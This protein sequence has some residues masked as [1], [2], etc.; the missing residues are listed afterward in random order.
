MSFTEPALQG[1]DLTVLHLIPSL[2][3]GGT[4]RQL[5][6]FIN[7]SSRPDRHFVALFSSLGP[8]ATSVPNPP[9]WL[10]RIGRRAPDVP[11]DVRALVAFRGAIRT[12]RADLVHAHLHMSELVAVAATPP[13]TP[14]VASRRGHAGRYE[15][16]RAYQVLER[17]AHRRIHVLICNST[18]LASRVGQGGGFTPRLEVIHN[19]I[20]LDA[21]AAAPFPNG[22]PTVAVVANLHPYKGHARLLRAMRVVRAKLPDAR[23]VVVGAGVE[24]ASLEQLVDDLGLQSVVGF[25]GQVDDPRP[26][27]RDAHVVA[28]TSD[29]EGFPNA[30]LEAM[31]MGR[32]VVASRVGGIPELVRDGL[33]GFLTT[34]DPGQIGARLIDLLGDEGLRARMGRSARRRA[35]SFGWDR[36]VRETEAVYRDVL[37]R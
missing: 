21:F 26:F 23:L 33:D 36:V 27:V 34:A 3:V 35:E 11:D 9:L 24:R 17:L 10:G 5:V 12:T 6:E 4:E 14:I 28:L 16:S 8:L 15:G 22:P 32:P 1:A 18:Y 29:H 25:A 13:G 7:R 31:A 37:G 30:L 19:G 20:D 2:E